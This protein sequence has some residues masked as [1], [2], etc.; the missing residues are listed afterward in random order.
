M[1]K[2]GLY[3]ESAF[4]SMKIFYQKIENPR[5]LIYKIVFPESGILC[6]TVTLVVD[7]MFSAEISAFI[8]RG[9]AEDRRISVLEEINRVNDKCCF[10]LMRQE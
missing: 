6:G 9:V 7:E 4:R 3:L 2:L 8:A 1:K 10:I 5:Q